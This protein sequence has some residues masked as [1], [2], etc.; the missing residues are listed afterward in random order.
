MAFEPENRLEETLVRAQDDV[1]ARPDFYR[2][3]MSEPLVIAGELVRRT[4]ESPPEGMNL[5]VIRHNGRVFHPVFTALKRLKAIAPGEQRH[6]LMVGRDMFGRAKGANFLLNPNSEF[7]RALMPAE[8]AFWLDPSARARR[9]LSKN[10]PRAHLTVPA[11]SPRALIE[12]LRVLF[13]H[14]HDVVAAHLLEVAFS[15]RDEPAHPLIV[16]ETAAQWEKLTTEVSELSAALIPDLI[17]DLVRHDPAD[18]DPG[19]APHL[20][21]TPAFYQR[22]ATE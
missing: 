19:L 13:A 2:L 10:P 17:I 11:E 1:L 15:D 5:A 22:P 6:F 7:S 16:I 20:A 9:T 14:R 21:Q 8:L 4:L 18:P 12:G 3:L